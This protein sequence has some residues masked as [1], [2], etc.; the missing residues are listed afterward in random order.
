MRYLDTCICV[1]FL[2][3]RLREGYSELRA[4]KP[5]SFALPAIVV[6]ELHYGAQHSANP[7]KDLRL[8]EAFTSAFGI[9]A[10]DEACA[11]E[12]GRLRQELAAAGSPIGDRDTMIAAMALANRATVVTDNFKD[13][14]RVSGLQLEVGAEVDFREGG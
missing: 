12:Y 10:F 2:R 8:V 3:G 14:R 4:A 6:A 13:F 5:G 9:V 7:E 11:K 1:E